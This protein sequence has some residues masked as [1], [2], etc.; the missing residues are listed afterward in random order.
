[1]RPEV[2]QLYNVIIEAPEVTR[3][4][5]RATRFDQLAA[6][7]HTT[8]LAAI[9]EI[10]DDRENDVAKAV[11]CAM[12]EYENKK[13]KE[14]IGE[15]AKRH[16]RYARENYKYDRLI[17]LERIYHFLSRP[18]SPDNVWRAS[19]GWPMH[20]AGWEVSPEL[21]PTLGRLRFRTAQLLYGALGTT[22][23]T[24][25]ND[26]LLADDVYVPGYTHTLPGR[27]YVLSV[28]YE[29]GRWPVAGDLL[30]DPC[31][32]FI[33]AR[34]KFETQFATWRDTYTTL[35]Q[36]QRLNRR[37]DHLEI[38]GSNIRGDLKA[39]ASMTARQRKE[40]PELVEKLSAFYRESWYGWLLIE[41]PRYA[42]SRFT[43]LEDMAYQS[44]EL[45]TV[46]RDLFGYDPNP[47]Q[48]AQTE[49][50]QTLATYYERMSQSIAVDKKPLSA[51]I[52]KYLS[53]TTPRKQLEPL[54]WH[55]IHHGTKYL[56]DI[57]GRFA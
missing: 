31:V 49:V 6:T 2:L 57:H 3:R 47:A 43:H 19:T 18:P 52:A 25:F 4:A 24:R 23:I 44:D 34:E 13:V 53:R 39:W 30:F 27:R 10:Y 55:V 26:R 38:F 15:L 29:D 36:E 45:L 54:T 40:S 37:L 20:P 16:P 12:P 7:A 5:R 17:I 42:T 46:L 35:W 9:A 22:F 11:M 41:S 32:Q 8:I 1:M 51:V 21:L 48:S 14:R 33:L 56:R 50:E 28:D